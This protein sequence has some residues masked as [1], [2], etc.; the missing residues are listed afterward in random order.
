MSKENCFLKIYF[1]IP[2]DGGEGSS[3]VGFFCLIRRQ[4][5]IKRDSQSF[6]LGLK[7]IRSEGF[8]FIGFDGI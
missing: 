2:L 3:R 4:T 7:T 5:G 8:R 1:S 6:S